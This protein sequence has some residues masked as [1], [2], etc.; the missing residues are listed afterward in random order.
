M[1]H[2][3]QMVAARWRTPLLAGFTFLA[4]LL[5]AGMSFAGRGL[6]TAAAPLGIVSLELAPDAARAGAIIESWRERH[7][8]A[9]LVDTLEGAV[10]GIPAG[11]DRTALSLTVI[12][13]LFICLYAPAL[14][15]ACVWL[16]ERS[17][18]PLPGIV[19]AW[20]MSLAALADAVENLAML[21]MLS[22]DLTDAASALARGCALLKFSIVALALVYTAVAA[23]PKARTPAR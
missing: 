18:W 11:E 4:L 22:G 17:R 13:F 15:M 16:G 7:P 12:D 1:L 10:Q 5:L 20:L 23:T 6:C 2:P 21:R 14:A 19:L 3:L 8:A 9:P